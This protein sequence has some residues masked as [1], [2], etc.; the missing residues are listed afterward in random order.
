MSN[1]RIAS[2]DDIEL[3]IKL[4]TQFL[5]KTPYKEMEVETER[6]R[7]WLLH[8]IANGV[9]LVA[10]EDSLIVGITVQLPFSAELVASELMWGST[11]NG[12]AAAKIEK[13]LLEAFEYWAR[14]IAKATVIQIGS[15]HGDKFLVRRGYNRCETLYMVRL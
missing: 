11:K 1:I 14:Q 4:C 5:V 15:F 6:L 9:V 13:K 3:L 8:T 2:S 7:A 10:D 12:L